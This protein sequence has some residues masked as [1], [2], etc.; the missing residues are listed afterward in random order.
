MSK[1]PVPD[2]SVITKFA[3]VVLAACA[4]MFIVTA[5]SHAKPDLGLVRQ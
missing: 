3:K 4:M 1:S 5:T 2:R